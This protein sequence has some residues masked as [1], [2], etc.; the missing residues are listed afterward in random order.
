MNKQFKISFTSKDNKVVQPLSCNNT[1]QFDNVSIL[2]AGQPWFG[3]GTM[4]TPDASSSTR[5]WLT[6]VSEGE[7]GCNFLA[8]VLTGKFGA[9]SIFFRASIAAA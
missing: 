5:R 3:D 9:F 2:L 1:I 4:F 6:G 7:K 8:K